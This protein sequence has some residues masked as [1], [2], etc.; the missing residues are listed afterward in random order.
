M[1]ALLEGLATGL[2]RAVDGKL[3]DITDVSRSFL[4][5]VTRFRERFKAQGIK[6]ATGTDVPGTGLRV[7]MK[8]GNPRS[9]GFDEQNSDLAAH[10]MPP[11]KNFSWV[12]GVMDYSSYRGSERVLK[13]HV[14]RIGN[15]PDIEAITDLT[16]EVADAVALGILE[17]LDEDLWPAATISP[18]VG[19]RTNS[20]IMSPR[21]PLLSGYADNAATGSGSYMYMGHNLNDGVM[22]NAKAV[23]S[24]SVSS[25]FG[26]PTLGKIRTRILMPLRHRKARVDFALTDDEIINYMIEQGEAK[27]TI[28]QADKMVFGSEDLAK[29]GGIVYI[30]NYRHNLLSENSLPRCIDFFDASTLYWRMKELN[31]VQTISPVQDE[32]TV[33][34]L[35]QWRF[36]GIF[37]ITS[38]RNNALAFGAALS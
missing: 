7:D 19:Y 25:P 6:V 4:D 35:M 32:P 29:Y 14:E 18:T 12:A 1:S 5:T 21:Y 13:D 15:N 17:I 10:K 38:P 16:M 24:G 26:T 31:D 33:A 8:T 2:P 22:V 9:E 3:H 20:K 36:K 23:S 37:L 11:Q 27:Y 28:D 30:A 34:A